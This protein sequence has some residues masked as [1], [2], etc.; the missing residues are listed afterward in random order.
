MAFGVVTEGPW[1]VVVRGQGFQAQLS[2]FSWVS[3]VH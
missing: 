2:G 3:K 1:S